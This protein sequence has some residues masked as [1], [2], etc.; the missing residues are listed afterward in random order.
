MSD[1]P[2]QCKVRV[3]CPIGRCDQSDVGIWLDISLGVP[4]FIF[5]QEVVLKSRVN[6]R[7]VR[8]DIAQMPLGVFSQS[9]YC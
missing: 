9:C 2:D 4:G 5:S 3:R 6:W 7:A 1:V 8:L